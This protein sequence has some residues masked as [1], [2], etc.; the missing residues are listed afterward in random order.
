MVGGN[1]N[2]PRGRRAPYQEPRVMRVLK[3]QTEPSQDQLAEMQQV[4]AELEVLK[5]ER[6]RAEEKLQRAYDELEQRIEARTAELVEANELL[7]QE[8]EERKR[9]EE[10]LKRTKEYLENVIDNSVDAIGIVARQGR[11]FLGS[12]RA[13]EIYGYQFDELRGLTAF[14]LYPHPERLDR[15]LGRV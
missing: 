5:A 7:R 12:R 11:V 15:M 4:T 8:I 6:R 9:T 3:K 10:E 1:P 13:A 2:M 14:D